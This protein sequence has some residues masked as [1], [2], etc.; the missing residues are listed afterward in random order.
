M[1]CLGPIAAI[2]GL[3]WANRETRRMEETGEDMQ[4]HPLI[5][6]SRWVFLFVLI[7]YGL[8]LVVVIGSKAGRYF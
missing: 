8:A 6:A 1:V 5:V 2:P 4:L 7:F 3:I